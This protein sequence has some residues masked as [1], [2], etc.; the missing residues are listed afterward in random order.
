MLGF[1]SLM[2]LVFYIFF[3]YLAFLGVQEIHIERYIP[4]RAFQGKLLIVLLSVTLG[5]AVSSF[6][7]S[8]IDNVRN[9]MF[10]FK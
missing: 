3:T 6:F 4:M 9:L 2:T 1:Q 8:I 7:I 5:F 10:L